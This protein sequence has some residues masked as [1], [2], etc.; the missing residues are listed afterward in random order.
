MTEEFNAPVQVTVKPGETVEVRTA[1]DASACLLKYWRHECADEAYTAAM[2]SCM[3]VLAGL[4]EPGIAREAFIRA[5][6]QAGMAV[7]ACIVV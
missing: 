2:K 1:K 7:A 6:R 3:R 5:A 4:A